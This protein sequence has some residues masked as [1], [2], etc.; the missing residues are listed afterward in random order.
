MRKIVFY[1]RTSTHQQE[2]DDTIEV[3][4]EKLKEIYKKQ[5]IY[6]IYKD[7]GYSGSFLERPA[8]TQLRNDAKKGLFD[9]VAVY[10]LDRLSRKVG[11]Q[12]L[13]IDEFK[14]QGIKIEVLGKNFEDTPQGEFSLTVLS[15]AAQLEK[16]LIT[17]R[18]RDGKYRKANAGKLIGCYPP[19]GYKLIKRNPDKGTEAHFELDP[20]ESY[21]VKLAFKIY[22]EKQSLRQTIKELAKA[23]I[24]GRGK[25]GKEG[26]NPKPFTPRTLKRILSNESYVGNFY[27]GKT[28]PCEPKNP[29]TIDKGRLTGRRLRDKSEWKLIKIPPIIDKT[30]F[31]KAQEILKY[32]AKHFLKETKYQYLCQGLVRCLKCG[33]VYTAKPTAKPYKGKRYIAYF[34]SHN[35]AKPIGEPRCK[36]RQISQRKLESVVWDYVRS[37]IS[38]PDKVKK[39]IQ[40][41]REKRERDRIFNERAYD[42]LMTEKMNI[43]T[44]KSK[45]LDLYADNK[46]TK[47]ELDNKI[48]ELN[49]QEKIIDR[50]IQ[51]VGNSL[52][53][54]E[55]IDSVE[56]EIEELCL[57]Y[58]QKITNPTFELKKMIVKKWVKEI[59]ITDRGDI[60]I[61]VRVP[62]DYGEGFNNSLAT[63]TPQTSLAPASS[64]FEAA[65]SIVA[66][67]V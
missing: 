19:Y 30:I 56:R 32:R 26:I 18:M 54:I 24:L 67:V 53:K 66:P 61:K 36:S 7:E 39:A 57:Q 11:H 3:Q 46:F 6:R 5:N 50:Q 49:N 28:Y 60:I 20:K 41:L 34:C 12:L 44:K 52:K 65:S 21:G 14:K 55:N 64:S 25:R 47:E 43:K 51:E 37:L 33:K 10:N 40:I 16:E 58:K 8:L 63:T 38:N 1:C 62:E 29:K 4:L 23:G 2:Q 22:L 9:I 45:I 35:F 31:N 27:W 48:I 17:Q 13:L 59:N 15:A 42:V